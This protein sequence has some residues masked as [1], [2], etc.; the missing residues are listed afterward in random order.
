VVFGQVEGDSA[1]LAANRVLAALR[2]SRQDAQLAIDFTASAGL[3]STVSRDEPIPPQTILK[4]ADDALYLAKR[5]G[6]NQLIVA[7]H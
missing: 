3:A 6:K 7:D 4:L 2:T 1:R 5:S